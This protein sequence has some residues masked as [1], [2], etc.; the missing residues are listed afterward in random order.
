MYENIEEAINA[1]IEKIKK[2]ED[3]S[4]PD[5][6]KADDYNCN[7]YNEFSLQHELGIFLRKNLIGYWK[8]FFEKNIYNDKKLEYTNKCSWVKKEIDLIAIKY[9]N[10]LFNNIEAKYAIELKFAKGKNAR[11]PENMFDFIRDIR[12][13]EQVKE[14]RNFTK[15]FV[16]II[17][18]AEKY[19]YNKNQ[20]YNKKTNWIYKIFR[21]EKNDNEEIS[22]D[23]PKELDNGKRFSH[24][25]GNKKR[26]KDYDNRDN[27][28][29][30]RNYPTTWKKLV[31]NKY[32]YLFIEIQ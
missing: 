13:M 26:E 14:Y 16:L 10:S 12:F 22:I 11:T 17:V 9:K 30:N 7:I 29:L 21:R 31:K 32:R 20:Y 25:T 4:L 19:Y 28:R 24:P 6:E 27:F 2:N 18:D 1:F 5:K 15:C 8:I 23:I 3:Y